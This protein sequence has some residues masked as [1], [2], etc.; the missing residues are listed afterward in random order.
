VAQIATN[1]VNEKCRRDQVEEEK[2]NSKFVAE[3]N[4]NVISP[5]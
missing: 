5:S 1:L 4:S 2:K 3:S